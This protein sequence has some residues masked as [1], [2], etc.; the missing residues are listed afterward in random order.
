MALWYCG[1]WQG[2]FL[3]YPGPCQCQP[4]KNLEVGLISEECPEML[5]SSDPSCDPA[6]SAKINISLLCP[7]YSADFGTI[8]I[9]IISDNYSF[10][11]RN[12]GILRL[13]G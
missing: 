10:G 8:H 2:I 7:Q 5:L 13:G 1:L 6:N 3:H 4:G 9:I 12:L 11:E